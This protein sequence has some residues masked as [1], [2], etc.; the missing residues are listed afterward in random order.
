MKIDYGKSTFT[1]DECKHMLNETNILREK[2][3]NHTPVLIQLKSNVLKMDKQKFLISNDINFNDFI[4]N[5]LKKKLIHLS[6]TDVLT[7][8]TVQFGKDDLEHCETPTVTE[9]TPNSKTIKDI[10]NDFKD[11]LTNLLILKISRQTTYKTV[12]GYMKYLSGY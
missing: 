3:P 5:T 7:L 11:P 4:N 10:Y 2:N 12:K 8:F 1:L 9:I 6:S